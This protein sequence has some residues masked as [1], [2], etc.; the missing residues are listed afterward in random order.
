MTRTYARYSTFA[1]GPTMRTRFVV[2]AVIISGCWTIAGSRLAAQQPATSS[3]PAN[4]PIIDISPPWMMLPPTHTETARLQE[5]SAKS[6]AVQESTLEPAGIP[7]SKSTDQGIPPATAAVMDPAILSEINA[8]R[9][10]LGDG[11]AQHLEGVLDQPGVP[12]KPASADADSSISGRQILQAAFD[13]EIRQL[14]GLKLPSQSC[15]PSPEENSRLA[16]RLRVAARYLE[17]AAA[18]L[19]E[20][21]RF[22][23]ADQLRQQAQILRQQAR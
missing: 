10:R 7:G 9:A 4:P 15:P 13:D 19:E 18:E 22:V 21:S 3:P 1:G 6:P 16:N 17:L 20:V 11:V 5:S 23:D 8:I 2:L 14:A 12:A